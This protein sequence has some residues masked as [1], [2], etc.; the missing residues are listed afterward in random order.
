MRPDD[1]GYPTR[2]VEETKLAIA[3]SCCLDCK[4]FFPLLL[5]LLLLLLL[6]LCC[7]SWVVPGH[8]SQGLSSSIWFSVVSS[9]D[10][11]ARDGSEFRVTQIVFHLYDGCIARMADSRRGSTKFVQKRRKCGAAE[12]VALGVGSSGLG[13][14]CDTGGLNAAPTSLFQTPV[15][16]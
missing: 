12:D 3:G 9:L 13:C 10:N 14:Q 7:A 15:S 5:F 16:Q 6:L 2:T 1:P 11:S 8:E 4:C